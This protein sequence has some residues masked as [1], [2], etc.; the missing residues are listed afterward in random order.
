MQV[1]IRADA[2][3]TIGAG[4]VMRCLTLA[5]Q[6][7]A[8]GG[9]VAFACRLHEGH[10]CGFIESKG[11]LVHRLQPKRQNDPLEA[12]AEG[13]P[14]PGVDWHL[15][16]REVASVIT[17]SGRVDWLVVDHYGLDT[18]W[19]E[20]LRPYVG[21]IFVIDDLADR[22]FDCDLL[23]D[24]TY[25]RSSN[26]YVSLVPEHCQIL[27][28]ARYALLRP[29]FIMHR[30]AAL[31]RR[32]HYREVKN[33][34]ISMGGM[35]TNNL[36]LRVL[37]VLERLALPQETL[38]NVVLGGQTPGIDKI[39]E[40]A[41]ASH[42]TIKVRVNVDDM[43]ALMT[44]ADLAF[45]SGGSTSWERCCLGL[46][47]ILVVEEKN[48]Q[49]VAAELSRHGAVLSI[50][51]TGTLD[52]DLFEAAEGIMRDRNRYLEMAEA[53]AAVC[54]GAGAKIVAEKMID[55]VC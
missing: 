38:I 32:K 28:G 50:P 31:G 48:Q 14:L 29:Q 1:L 17:T 42:L 19:Q 11:Y 6:L 37:E 55:H 47:T 7:Q 18:G 45:G 4:H 2:S 51:V 15:D 36:T 24:Q 52:M 33:I 44:E 10:L 9:N 23:L 27:T 49:R 16:A 26:D 41:S 12:K 54:S 25:G 46:P 20:W 43:A 39:R 22:H 8:T 21:R 40:K 53:A 13:G 30:P 3:I 34:F 5:E 35:D